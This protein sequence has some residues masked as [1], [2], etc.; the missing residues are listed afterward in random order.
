MSAQG[1]PTLFLLIL[2]H[3][4][5]CEIYKYKIIHKLESVYQQINKN[6]VIFTRL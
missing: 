4:R 1:R 5:I 6:A 3:Q 2:K